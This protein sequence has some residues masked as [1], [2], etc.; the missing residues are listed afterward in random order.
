MQSYEKS[1]AKQK[2][3]FFFLPRRSKFA[4]A[5]VKVTE[6]DRDKTD[7]IF[8]PLHQKDSVKNKNNEKKDGNPMQSF[9]SSRT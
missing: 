6:K 8:V 1:S 4:I 5:Y 3:L 2:N 9:R 7:G